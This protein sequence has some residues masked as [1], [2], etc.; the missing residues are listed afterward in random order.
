M[1]LHVANSSDAL[2]IPVFSLND[3]VYQNPFYLAFSTFLIIFYIL[4]AYIILRTCSIFLSIKVFHENMNILMAW[5]LLQWFEAILAKMVI[6][7]YQ[8]GLIVIGIDPQKSYCS[9]SS[10]EKEDVLVVKDTSDIMPL[11]ISSC[12]LWHYMASI[13]FSIVAITVERGCATYFM[14]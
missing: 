14:E 4:I 9:W 11:Y 13:L 8:I 5:F 6:I 7:P 12:F 3:R 10:I 2:W 1:I